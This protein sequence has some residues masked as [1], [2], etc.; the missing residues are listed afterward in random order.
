[1]VSNLGL[2]QTI[3]TAIKRVGGPVKAITLLASGITIVT[4]ASGIGGYFIGKHNEKKKIKAK[5]KPQS[6]KVYTVKKHGES[7]EGL[8]F[9]EG[10]KFIV[11]SQDKD[12]VLIE[13]IGDTN[14][15]YF[16]SL[17]LL[18]DISDFKSPK[19]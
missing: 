14:N 5:S 7:N 1:M 19:D 3:T 10:D 6:K 4:G 12:A 8:V 11:L 17:E 16:V 15:P 18:L 2:Y 13:K 9:N